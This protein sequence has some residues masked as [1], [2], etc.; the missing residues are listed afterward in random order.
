MLRSRTELL[1]PKREIRRDSTQHAFERLTPIFDDVPTIHD[2]LG[3]GSTKLHTA[4]LLSGAISADPLHPRMSAKPGD[5][6]FHSRIREQ[7]DR[8]V[9]LPINKE[10]PIV[11]ITTKG[12][13]IHAKNGRHCDFLCHR[14]FSE[15]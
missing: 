9:M 7:V 10:S 14:H 3:R 1:L 13:I 12:K 15:A 11:E 6:G 4:S 8:A 2:L 5:F